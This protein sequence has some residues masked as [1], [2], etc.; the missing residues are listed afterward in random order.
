MILVSGGTDEY[1]RL[2]VRH[3]R[4]HR[5]SEQVVLLVDSTQVGRVDDPDVVVRSVGVDDPAFAAGFAGADRVLI[6]T[7]TTGHATSGQIRRIGAAI[8]AAA[9]VGA[10]R[11]AYVS[12]SNVEYTGLKWHH[13][14]EN[15]VRSTGIPYTILRNALHSEALLPAVRLALRTGELVCAAG[16]R[17]LAFGARTD[18]AEA[19]AV[20]LVEDEHAG[21][22]YELTGVIP[23]KPLGIAAVVSAIAGRQ[24]P[25]RLVDRSAIADELRRA[26]LTSEVAAQLQELYSTI[27]HGDWHAAKETLSRLLGRAPVP[28]EAALRTGLATSA[29]LA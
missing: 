4:V 20:A 11:I 14:Y 24:I 3:L 25:L 19:A 12:V 27:W 21:Q 9:E 22:T 10:H 7:G 2:V 23:L 5:P 6:T 17:Q 15:R 8:D 16:D 29:L 26:G 18:Y 13:G 28:L 1:S